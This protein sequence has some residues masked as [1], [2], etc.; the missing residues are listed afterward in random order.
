MKHSTYLNLGVQ[1][2]PGR[3]IT[4]Y[5]IFLVESQEARISVPSLYP[6]KP[7]NE[8][9]SFP[10]VDRLGFCCT[11]QTCYKLATRRVGH[12]LSLILSRTFCK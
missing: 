10:V 7:G 6:M 11:G 3:V 12:V 4:I 5:I 9:Y 2:M 8:G 1:P